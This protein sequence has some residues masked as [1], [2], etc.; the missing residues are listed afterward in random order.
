M[1]IL[2]FILFL[3]CISATAIAQ[4]VGIGTNTPLYPLTVNGGSSANTIY[5]TSTSSASGS[6]GS[7]TSAVLGELTNTSGGGYSAGV[8]GINRSTTGSG[9]GV[10]GYQAGAGYGVYGETPTGTGVYG[11]SGSG[12]G[13]YFTSSG[14]VP[15]VSGINSNSSVAVSGIYGSSASGVYGTVLTG[16]S[17][18]FG[19]STLTGPGYYAAGVRGISRSTGINGIGVIG[20]QAG[21]GYGVY[22]ESPS[23]YGV[24]GSSATGSGG[25]FT[26]SGSAP[27]VAAYNSSSGGSVSGVYGSTAS[28]QYGTVLSGAS[29]VFGEATLTNP[30]YYAAGVRGICRSTGAYGIGV[31]GYQ[32]GSGYGV[33]GET[34]TGYAVFGN[35]TGSGAGGYFQSSSGPGLYVI[36]NTGTDIAL[37]LTGAGNKARIDN[38]GK[39]FFNGGTQNNG[40]DVAESFSVE[41]KR[42][43]YEPGDVLAIS[44]GADRTV[45][46]SSGA[47]SKLVVG[48]Y[49]TKPGVLL[50]QKNMDADLKDEVPMGVVGVIPTKVCNE[51]GAIHRGDL[52][53]SASRAGYAMKADEDKIKPGMLIG[54]ALA[55]MDG[56]TGL[57]EV[58]VNVR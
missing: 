29:G 53:V 51:G 52:L 34:P 54:K 11:V 33:Y 58:M 38:T 50:T 35:S 24:F 25:Y 8:R 44:T 26:S 30:G 45:T 3:C 41:G 32:A 16:A 12:P 40:A 46:K 10:I 1:K 20:Y 47:Y 55:D 19:E 57:I 15:T 23:G 37:F 31:I 36:S 6:S 56:E 5:G 14:S 49:A 7:G 42:A 4:N 43:A 18:V 13:G 17:G 9:I 48:V 2:H 27:T 21:S 39:G 28:G 22:G